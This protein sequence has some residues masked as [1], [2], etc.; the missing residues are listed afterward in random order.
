MACLVSG[1]LW[2]QSDWYPALAPGSAQMSTLQCE[3]PV[4]A[5]ESKIKKKLCC[6]SARPLSTG[7]PPYILKLPI[8]RKAGFMFYAMVGFVWEVSSRPCLMEAS[9]RLELVFSRY[10]FTFASKVELTSTYPTLIFDPTL[11][12]DPT[13]MFDPTLIFDSTLIFDRLV[14][15]WGK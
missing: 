5:H 2:L 14:V 1:T 12:L 15:P 11:S 6:G 7:D 13:L 4:H 9:H 10:L 8:N 3:V